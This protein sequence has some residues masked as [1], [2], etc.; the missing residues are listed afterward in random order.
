MARPKSAQARNDALVAAAGVVLDV[1]VGAFTVDEVVRRSGVAKTTIY[2]HWGSAQNLLFE[3]VGQLIVPEPQP[4]TGSLD[5]DL[6]EVG[7]FLLDIPPDLMI[8]SR[9]VFA[10]LLAASVDDPEVAEL[11]A[12]LRE[13]RRRPVLEVLRRAAERGEI[14]ARFGSSPDLDLAADVAV[15]PFFSR[16]LISDD[17]LT[18]RDVKLWASMVRRALGDGR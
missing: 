9:R 8:R 13:N 18:E 10:G 12:R 14:D 5:T 2:R 4:D 3:A 7:Q 16:A 17:P 1:G 11:F 15:G 6:R